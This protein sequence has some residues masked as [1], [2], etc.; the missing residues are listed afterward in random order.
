MVPQI[1]AEY[2]IKYL[3]TAATIL[4]STGIG[5]P[6]AL[7]QYILAV[8]VTVFILIINL[9]LGYFGRHIKEGKSK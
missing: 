5:I 9:L 2:K 7:R 1:K 8:G 4:F 3:T 6:V